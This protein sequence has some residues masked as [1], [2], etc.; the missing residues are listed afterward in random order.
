MDGTGDLFYRQ[1]PGLAATFEIRTFS[2]SHL[3]DPTWE[4]LADAVVRN[5]LRDGSGILCGESFGGCL[6]LAIATRFPEVVDGL[7]LVNSASSF[8]QAPLLNSASAL[9]PA[10]PEGIL[11]AASEFSLNWLCNRERL[12]GVDRRRF[13][14]AIES[15]NKADMLH[16]LQ[17]LKQFDASKRPLEALTCPTLLLASQGDRLL[18]SEREAHYLGSRLPSAQIE[19]L[20]ESGHAC[21]L[22]RNFNLARMLHDCGWMASLFAYAINLR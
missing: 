20:P 5:C 14:Q 3:N 15:V 2:F 18:P 19:L 4:D 12:T 22:E 21:L 17:L 13:R 16:R 1:E 10:I 11:Q 6:A 8:Q 7:I 9:L